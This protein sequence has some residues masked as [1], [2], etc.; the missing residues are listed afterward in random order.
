MV[1][2]YGLSFQ[3][4]DCMMRIVLFVLAFCCLVGPV[5]AQERFSLEDKISPRDKRYPTFR[6]ALELMSSRGAK[7]LV[8]TGTARNGRANCV[9]DGCSTLVFAE[10]ASQHAALLY[11]V[12]IDQLA[13]ITAESCLGDLKHFVKFVHDDS[14]TFLKDF[15][16]P[17]DFLYLDS[18]DFDASDPH[19]SQ[20]HHLSEII[21]AYPWLTEKSI[22]L[23]DDCALPHGGKGK[24][25]IQYL[26][27][28]GWVIDKA[29]YQ[30]LMVKKGP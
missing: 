20:Q 9:G 25:V 4:E 26:W 21:A 13:L 2:L 22:V 14:I 28:R 27:D 8:E 30:I 1:R 5:N 29:D 6:R 11:S 10:W 16:Q 15:N 7:T 18:Y 24:L 12:D 17:I 19:P 23:I 3:M